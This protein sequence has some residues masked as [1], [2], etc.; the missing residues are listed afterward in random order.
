MNSGRQHYCAS[1]H[2]WHHG[3]WGRVNFLILFPIVS[4]EDRVSEVS[5]SSFPAWL[6]KVRHFWSNVVTQHASPACLVE[7][8]FSLSSGIRGPLKFFSMSVMS[9]FFISP[10]TSMADFTNQKLRDARWIKNLIDH[11]IV[12]WYASACYWAWWGTTRAKSLP[13]LPCSHGEID[14]LRSS[15]LVVP[16]SC[17]GTRMLVVSHGKGWFCHWLEGEDAGGG[18]VGR[19]SSVV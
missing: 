1:S 9:T 3:I 6:T 19:A 15:P 18:W 5:A 11:S 12:S 16:R 14:R 17:A 2:R 8:L 13:P 7:E 4:C 10:D